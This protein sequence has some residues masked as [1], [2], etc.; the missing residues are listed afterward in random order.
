MAAHAVARRTVQPHGAARATCGSSAANDRQPVPPGA[1]RAPAAGALLQRRHRDRIRARTFPADG[2]ARLLLQ[3]HQVPLPLRL[4]RRDDRQTPARDVLHCPTQVQADAFTAPIAIPAGKP[5]HLRVEV[6][7]ERL[8]LRLSR[9]R[10]TATGTGCRSSST[11]AFSP[12]KR[13]RRACRISPAPSSDGCQDMPA[14]RCRRIS[15]GSSIASG[16]FARSPLARA[17][18]RN[19]LALL[20]AIDQHVHWAGRARRLGIRLRRC[21][22]VA[23]VRRPRIVW[24]PL[25]LHT[26]RA[27]ATRQRIPALRPGL[28]GGGSGARTD[29]VPIASQSSIIAADKYIAV[30]LARPR[31]AMSGACRVVAGLEHGMRVADICRRRRPSRFRRVASA[32]AR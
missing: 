4:A 32:A 2:R 10:R 12:T 20:R 1:R 13:P 26:P 24:C 29:A 22:R 23:A 31:P 7:Y 21:V 15:T 5:V 28:L 27:R 3:Q 6:D 17:T 25:R 11:P 8:L 18:S 19:N 30:G 9:R 14:R 16:L